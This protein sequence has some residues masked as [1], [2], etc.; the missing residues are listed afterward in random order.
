M[1]TTCPESSRGNAV[2]VAVFLLVVLAA[3]GAFIV[4]ISSSQQIG[5]AYDA[6]GARAYQAA[7]YGS[8]WGAYQLLKG[9]CSGGDY[10]A[11]CRGATYAAPISQNLSGFAGSLSDF[12]VTVYCGSGGASYSEGGSTLWVYQ[13]TANAC[14]QPS[15][16]ACPNTNATAVSSIGY[17]E[18][19]V[20][21]TVTN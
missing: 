4:T 6:Q 12:T 16:G 18:R 15:G 1:S 21:L 9:A 3:L 2:V 20:S 19:R 7:H 5:S 13:I 14:N 17:I 11:N 10:C 8:E